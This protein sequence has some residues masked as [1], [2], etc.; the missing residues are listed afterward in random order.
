MT[1]RISEKP[2]VAQDAADKGEAHYADWWAKAGKPNRQALAGEHEA[3]KLRAVDADKARTVETVES[4]EHADFVAE[5][6]GAAQ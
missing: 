3:L 1:V 5:L 6:D 4:S 2:V